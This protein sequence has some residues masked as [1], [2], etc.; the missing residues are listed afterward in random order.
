MIAP[1]C[2]TC[3]G[4]AFQEN[5]LCD[6]AASKKDRKKF[7][8]PAFK[9][10]LS[11]LGKSQT[12]R[13]PE[14]DKENPGENL[15]GKTKW[16]REFAKQELKRNPDHVHTEIKYHVCLVSRGRKR[17]LEDTDSFENA[18]SVLYDIGAAYDS[19]IKLI[20]TARDHVHLFI[21]SGPDYP[22]DK[23]VRE[24]IAGLEEVFAKNSPEAEENK[25]GI[26]ES[27]YFIE[28]LG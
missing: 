18:P 3:H 12:P 4:L 14:S 17:I 23:I 28:T 5:I 27:D 8:C 6:L 19:E 13:T 25:G 16:F 24:T 20:G 7:K 22:A 2:R 1:E 21:E 10:N 26:F 15:S 11:L 9:P